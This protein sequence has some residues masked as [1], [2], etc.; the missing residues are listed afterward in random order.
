MLCIEV[1]LSPGHSACFLLVLKQ[2]KIS[3]I[4]ND[5]LMKPMVSGDTNCIV[6]L[7]FKIIFITFENFNFWILKRIYYFIS[8]R[9]PFIIYGN[10]METGFNGKWLGPTIQVPELTL[11]KHHPWATQPSPPA[12][13]FTFS[14]L[15][16]SYLFLLPL[17]REKRQSTYSVPITDTD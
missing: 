3:Q 17:V 7:S 2:H 4:D 5:F 11:C 16:L 8:Q 13:L 12:S 14:S 9:K 15:P 10:Y 6:S 1:M